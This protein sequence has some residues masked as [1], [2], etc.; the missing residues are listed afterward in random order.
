MLYNADPRGWAGLVRRADLVEF[1]FITP[2]VNV[3]SILQRRILSHARA[4]R[5]PEKPLSI[6]M[7]TIQ[8]LREGR[9]AWRVPPNYL[10]GAYVLARPVR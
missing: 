10:M 8:D 4:I 3:P 5:L 2:I 9:R 6:A 7:Q 1:C